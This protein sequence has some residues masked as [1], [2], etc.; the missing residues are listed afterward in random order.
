MQKKE[1][2]TRKFSRAFTGYDIA[3]VDF[4]LDE[5]YRE[6]SLMEHELESLRARL[7]AYEGAAQTDAEASRPAAES[8]GRAEIPAAPL[9]ESA[10]QPPAA[11]PALETAAWTEEAPPSAAD[12]ADETDAA[13]G[14]YFEPMY[15]QAE[16]VEA[17]EMYTEAEE[18][19]FLMETES[20]GYAFIRED[21]AQTPQETE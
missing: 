16:Y 13:A 5:L 15:A 20:P 6:F 3:E 4:F 12:A 17:E 14:F 18:A 1:I 9:R 19:A 8:R 2:L 11:E 7:D 21:A 10:A